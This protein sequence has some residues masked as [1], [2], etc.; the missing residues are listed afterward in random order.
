MVHSEGVIIC[1]LLSQAFVV[2]DV[3]YNKPQRSA[4]LT[5]RREIK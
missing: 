1:L 4:M 3:P 5:E 2:T